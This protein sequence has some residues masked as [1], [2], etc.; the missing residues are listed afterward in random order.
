MTGHLEWFVELQPIPEGQWPIQGISSQLLYARG[1][2]RINI[3]R[4]IDNEWR[5]S[6]L[7]EVLCIPG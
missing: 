1:I 5:S 4:L 6:F 2:G 7:K 3:E